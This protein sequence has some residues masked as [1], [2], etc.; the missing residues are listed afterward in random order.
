LPKVPKPYNSGRWSEARFRAFVKSAL[1]KASSRW[2][3]QS[4]VLKKA[5]TGTRKNRFTGRQAMHFKCSKCRKSYP[6]THV[7][8][9]HVNP[10]EPF[11]GYSGETYLGTNWNTYIERLLCEDYNYQVLC[12]NCHTTKT[13][14][15]NERRKE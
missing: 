11:E 10:V 12:T 13:N 5:Q 1:R 7:Q 9:D 2:Q 6:R 15:E 3:V 4:D 14:K 8:V